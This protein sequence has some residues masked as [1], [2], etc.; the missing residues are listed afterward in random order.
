MVDDPFEEE[1]AELD[2]ETNSLCSIYIYCWLTR[3]IMHDS[4]CY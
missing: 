4:S 1:Q 2:N 3:E